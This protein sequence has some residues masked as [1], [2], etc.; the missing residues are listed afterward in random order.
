MRVLNIVIF[1]VSFIIAKTVQYSEQDIID[2]ITKLSNKVAAA[3][4]L[5]RDDFMEAFQNEL[6]ANFEKANNYLDQVDEANLLV[7]KDADTV[8]EFLGVS[9]EQAA[10]LNLQ[11]LNNL[12]DNKAEELD[13]KY[14][15]PNTP[16]EEKIGW[17]VKRQLQYLFQNEEQRI[18]YDKFVSNLK[19]DVEHVGDLKKLTILEDLQNDVVKMVGN[20]PEFEGDPDLVS[21]TLRDIKSI[22]KSLTKLNSPTLGEALK[23]I[24][25]SI[26]KSIQDLI[27]K[28][29]SKLPN[30]KSQKLAWEKSWQKLNPELQG[31]I[32]KSLEGFKD[33]SIQDQ[34]K[35]QLAENPDLLGKTIKVGNLEY[36]YDAQTESYDPVGIEASEGHFI[37]DVAEVIK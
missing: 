15:Q 17:R 25:S 8:Y 7:G 10:K 1:C 26:K 28:I 29:S 4:K 5:A 32:T 24:I 35:A 30:I 20:V 16:N 31:K 9:D 3:Q 11:Q 14:P 2:S 21:Q 27:T 12:L 22:E 19:N 6:E 33:I 18:M 13:T 34:I 23:K 37:G 36:D